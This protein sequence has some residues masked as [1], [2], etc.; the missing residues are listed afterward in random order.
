MV[1]GALSALGK[2]ELVFVETTMNAQK[3]CDVLEVSLIPFGNDEHNRDYYFQQD[4]A[5][6]HVAN[7]TKQFF[8]DMNINF[9]D[10]LACS[11]DHNPI[12]NHWVVLVREMYRGFR[13]FDDGESLKEAILYGWEKSRKTSFV[14]SFVL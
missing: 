5:S 2:A 3:Y 8:Q 1:R 9:L 12:E 13:E 6:V 4:N 14:N 7:N 10:W 11:P